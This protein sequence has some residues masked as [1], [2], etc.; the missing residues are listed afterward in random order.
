MNIIR[1][2]QI[3]ANEEEM[4]VVEVRVS[5]GEHVRSGEILCTLESTKATV[6]LEAPHTGYV[7]KLRIQEGDRICVGDPICAVT[8]SLDEEVEL[9]PSRSPSTLNGGSRATRRAAALIEE[10]GVDA[11]QVEHEGIITEYAVLRHLGKAEVDLRA[12]SDRPAPSP[13]E[14]GDDT[15]H[16]VVIYGAGGHAR[17]VIDMIR[18]GRRDLRI[19]GIVDDADDGPD[20]VMGIP[21]VGDAGRLSE[22]RE[23]GIELAALGI[24]AVTHNALRAELFDRL[25]SR[26]F[27]LPN[28]IHPRATVEP[29]VTMGRGNQI[30][31]GATV[32]SNV[33]L[34]DNVI[35]NSNAVVSH[36][37]RIEDHVHLTPGSLLAGAVEVGPRS[38]IGMGSTV[39]LGVEVGADV[40]VANG[41]HILSDVGDEEVIRR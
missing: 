8:Q 13:I 15:S 10:Y 1:A 30:F 40:V 7:R 36:D 33:H 11:S 12:P 41:N 9:E 4:E 5:E 20:E 35:V 37:C 26:G 22:L 29:S 28:L 2:P 24:G 39:Y 14:V 6:D 3:N 32:S 18:E 25:R 21:I 17:V 16:A 34:G 23:R 19:I 27:R 31:A 38:V